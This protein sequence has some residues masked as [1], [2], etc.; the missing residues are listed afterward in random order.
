MNRVRDGNKDIHVDTNESI[1]CVSNFC[2]SFIGF[3]KCTQGIANPRKYFFLSVF[4]RQRVELNPNWGEGKV[5]FLG[6]K[7][8]F[9]ISNM[10][11][12]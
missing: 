2:L 3:G 7:V 11:A 1:G 9:P 6:V 4:N 8:F 10:E 12:Y 5:L